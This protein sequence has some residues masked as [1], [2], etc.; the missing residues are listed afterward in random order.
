MLRSLSTAISGLRNH[1]TKLDVVGN[2]ISNVNTVGYKYETVH[3]QDIFS[4]TLKDAN[5]PEN[6]RGGTNPL[7]VGVGMALSSTSTSHTQ[8]A[9]TSTSRETDVAIEGNGFFVVSD[10]IQNYY[11][12]DGSFIRGNT[13]ELA[14]ANGF[15]LMGWAAEKIFVDEN[16]VPVDDPQDAVDEVYEIDTTKPLSSI[17]IPLGEETLAKAT[18]N[19]VFAGNLN[20]ESVAEGEDGFDPYDYMTYFYDSLGNRHDMT[21]EFKKTAENEWGYALSFTDADGNIV[22]IEGDDSLLFTE[23]GTLISDLANPSDYSFTIDAETLGT[24][25]RDIAVTLDFSALNQYSSSTTAFVR[26]QDGFAAGELS[27]FTIE[28]SGVVTGTYSNG[29]IR[30]L[31]QIALASFANPEG[32]VKRGSNLFD[33]TGNS[34]D[35]RIGLPGEQGRGMLKSCALEMSNV[36]LAFEFSEMITT[37]RG[38]QANARVISTSDEVLVELINVKR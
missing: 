33:F 38:Y 15:K 6:G 22:E 5:A 4:Q 21:V 30:E 32:M 28:A 7:Q 23:G 17:L 11:T 29:M 20:S 18:E 1:Q 3:F 26:D 27:S 37:S 13:G 8:G 12:R 10:G 9:I 24:G 25:S 14:T 31:G 16:G 19:I 36:D 34:G 35:P 2:N